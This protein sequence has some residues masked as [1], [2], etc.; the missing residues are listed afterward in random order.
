MTPFAVASSGSLLTKQSEPWRV[1]EEWT[2]RSN[3]ETRCSQNKSAYQLIPVCSDF[4]LLWIDIL[5]LTAH[6][7]LLRSKGCAQGQKYL[8]PG[9]QRLSP[10]RSDPGSSPARGHLLNVLPSISHTFLSISLYNKALKC[11]KYNKK[12]NKKVIWFKPSKL[13]NVRM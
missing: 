4:T 9:A 12:N 7:Q 2:W 8:E 6:Y 13:W 11:K 5:L 3:S 1:E 10:K